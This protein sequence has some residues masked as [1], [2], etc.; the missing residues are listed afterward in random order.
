MVWKIDRSTDRW[1]IKKDKTVKITPYFIAAPL[2]SFFAVGNPKTVSLSAAAG[3]A[4]EEEEEAT[5]NPAPLPVKCVD[6]AE[7]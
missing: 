4:D 3:A 2:P 7:E 6:V 5:E 1:I